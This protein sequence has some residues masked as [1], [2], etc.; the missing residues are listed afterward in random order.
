MY[1]IF[2]AFYHFIG[3]CNFLIGLAMSTLLLISTVCLSSIPEAVS[4]DHWTGSD[5]PQHA[6]FD[7]VLLAT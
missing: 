6:R 7:Y 4:F 1:F 2:L 5:T 3:T